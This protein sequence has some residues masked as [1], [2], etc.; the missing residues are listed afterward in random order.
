MDSARSASN[1]GDFNQ[2]TCFLFFPIF[3]LHNRSAFNRS[4][5]LVLLISALHD[6]LH[7]R[8]AHKEDVR[9]EV[10]IGHVCK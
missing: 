4:Q 9:V 5:R 6:F 7:F 2:F 1:L 3:S 10:G 8:S